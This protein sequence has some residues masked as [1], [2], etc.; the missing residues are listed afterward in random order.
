VAHRLHFAGS[1]GE[2][3]FEIARLEGGSLSI[4][5]VPDDKHEDVQKMEAVGSTLV[6]GG[7]GLVIAIAY[8]ILGPG[9][10]V[11]HLSRLALNQYSYRAGRRAALKPSELETIKKC[12]P[13]NIGI[14]LLP[15]V[16]LIS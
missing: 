4:P 5:R 3:A 10:V 2:Q 16:L 6:L 13:W 8:L 9:A 15:A 12:L 11:F 1:R 14:S 7:G